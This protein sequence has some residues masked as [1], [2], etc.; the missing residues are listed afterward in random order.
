MEEQTLLLSK[1]LAE[2]DSRA[3]SKGVYC[4]S[5]FLGLGEQSLLPAKP[6]S[7]LTLW[8]GFPLAERRIASFSPA[9]ACWE[10]P[11]PIAT[12]L[13][14]PTGGRFAGALSHRDFLGSLMGL[15]IKREVLGDIIL[16]GN[17]AYIFC[18]DS[19]ADFICDNLTS[20]RHDNVK[21]T[22]LSEVPKLI[23]PKPAEMQIIV[24]GERVDALVAS[25]FDLSRSSAKALFDSEKV[26]INGKLSSPEKKT[27]VGA[28]VSV[29]GFG[30]FIYHG[31]DK[32]TRRGRLCATVEI[33]R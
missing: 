1:R 8:G 16:N 19:I 26:F 25:V 24:S 14:V 31:I 7:K 5:S 23:L 30:R 27:P 29:R 32:Q 6:L 11:F 13:A 21:C 28:I 15:G 4:F 33:Y 17:K 22:L 10:E 9:D 12:L 20:V 3:H 18:I 2:L